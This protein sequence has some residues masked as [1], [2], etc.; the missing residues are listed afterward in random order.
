MT[1]RDDNDVTRTAA[2]TLSPASSGAAPAL[3]AAVFELGPLTPRVIAGGMAVRAI[4]TAAS[5]WLTPGS[6]IFFTRDLNHS[7][8]ASISISA[9]RRHGRR[10]SLREARRLAM[11]VSIDVEHALQTE[12]AAEAL[13]F[14]RLWEDN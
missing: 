11:Q 8:S 14:S 9:I 13:V 6:Q 10:I 2:N 1:M 3:T 5:L 4:I 7:R 12:R